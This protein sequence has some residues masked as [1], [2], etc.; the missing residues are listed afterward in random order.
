MKRAKLGR[1]PIPPEEVRTRHVRVPVSEA[2]G[3]VL[4]AWSAREARPLAALVRETTLRAAK[5]V[6]DLTLIPR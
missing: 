4:D 1:P 2:E 5:R 6:R 3:Q